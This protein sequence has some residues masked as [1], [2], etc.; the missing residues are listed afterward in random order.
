MEPRL[1]AQRGMSLV[2]A[3]IILMVLMLLTGVLAPSIN[4]YVNDA[5]DVKVKE[6]CE[7]IGATVMRLVRDVGPCLKFNADG[8]NQNMRRCEKNNRVDIL[9]SEGPDVNHLDLFGDAQESFNGNNN[10][11]DSE[12]NW[13][14]E[15][16]R[17][18]SME[19]QFVTN[20][21]GP[22]YPTPGT[23][24]TF[25][26]PGPHFN[27]GWRGA[28][29]SSP[30][31]PDPWGRRYLVNTVFLSTARDANWGTGEGEVS[32][33]WS[34]DVFCVSGGRNTL[35]ETWFG[36]NQFSGTSRGGDDFVY[37]ISGSSR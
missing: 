14:D 9:F 19:H 20:D 17:G 4:D 1:R 12:I 23:L 24:G 6:D 7:A 15:D 29:L 26:R 27:L 37:V 25:D 21:S 2:E 36:G 31:G 11:A 8:Q 18:D 5:K 13:N 22:R 30:V 10:I 35:Y 34:H 28:Y 3:T 16:Q 33:G 32:G